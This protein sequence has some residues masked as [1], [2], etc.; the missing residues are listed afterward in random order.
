[1]IESICAVMALGAFAVIIDAIVT[2]VIDH[3]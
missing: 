1:M 3:M 2:T